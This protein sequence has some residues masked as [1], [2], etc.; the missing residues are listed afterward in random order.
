[1]DIPLNEST[2][3]AT[4]E[5]LRLL[6]ENKPR[7]AESVC[8]AWCEKTPD[9][10]QAWFLLGVARH[11]SG[12]IEGA[13]AAF[14]QAMRLDSRDIQALS[15]KAMMLALLDRQDAALV[16]Y[17]Q[18]LALNPR[19]AQTLANI[20]IVLERKNDLEGALAHYDSALECEPDHQAALMSRGIVL[21]RLGRFQEALSNNDRL[22][23]LYPELADAHF[24]RAEVLLALDRFEEALG[25][26]ARVLAINPRHVKAHIDQGLALSALGRLKE[27]EEAF[28][29]AQVIDQ[30]E[31]SAYRNPLEKNRDAAEPKFDPRLIYLQKGFERQQQC[32]W[33]DRKAY[34][35]DFEN[36]VRASLGTEDEIHDRAQAFH[37]I[38]LPVSTEIRIAL[39]KSAASHI[40]R[41]VRQPGHYRG[42]Q[43]DRIKVG[44][45]SPDFRTHVISHVT[46]L[47]Y[48]LHDHSRFEVYGYA[49]NPDDGS[50]VRRE[51]EQDCDRFVELSELSDSQAAERILSDG[52]DILV[53][54]AGYTTGA[55]SEIFALRPAPLQVSYLGF[56]GTTGAEYMDYFIT[57]PTA[58]PAA[59]ENLWS[60]KL[61]FLPHTFFI[62]NNRQAIP[63]EPVTRSDLGLP[64]EAFVF[65]CFSNNYKIEPVV[66][67][68]WMRLLAKLPGSVLW[69]YQA[70]HA[71]A[72]NLRK[73]AAAR[74]V[75][76]DRIVFAAPVELERYLTR[77]RHADL[78]LDTLWYN[79]GTT[80]CDALWTGLPVLTCIG[81]TMPSRMAASVLNAAGLPEMVVTSL[82]QYEDKAFFLATH[83]WELKNIREKLAINR[84]SK[85]L[86]DTESRVRELESAYR[87]M[88]ERHCAGLPPEAF[89]VPA[90]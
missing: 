58:C 34:L 13:L 44:Y 1:M 53:D 33:S 77:Y 63:H 57:D 61:V 7:Q 24:N 43:R 9:S 29:R 76:P 16:T 88:W 62:Y 47:L 87:I 60:E 54:L 4:Q 31:F 84:A 10:E 52:V 56:P 55:R 42:R 46:R 69:L 83:P 25:A 15:A 45:V 26:C 21:T 27:A 41:S 5:I 78:F 14:D 79:A 75:T 18:A 2:H 73:E 81:Q 40:A 48:A 71:V 86:F 39:A 74:G 36:L 50:A 59:E 6:H 64:A 89:H 35:A 23:S 28:E 11:L 38:A 22:A 80:A 20:A 3:P 66:F 51:I 70:N 30:Q 67:D 68:I 49:L 19:D 65:C 82:Q 17:R 12:N 90:V 37:S 72:G 85:P 32:D 8:A